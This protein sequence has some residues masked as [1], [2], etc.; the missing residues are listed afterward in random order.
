MQDGCK[1]YVHSY[2]ATNRSC[3]MLTWTVYLNRLLEVGLTQNRDVKI[4]EVEHG[5]PNAH[6]C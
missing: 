4:V 5:T 1:V 2:M 3:F 6:N